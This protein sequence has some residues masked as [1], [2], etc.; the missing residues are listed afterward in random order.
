VDVGLAGTWQ[1]DVTG[2]IESS[3]GNVTLRLPRD[4]GVVVNARTSFGD[5]LTS[6]LSKGSLS[7]TYVNGRYGKA[8]VTLR[9]NVRSSAGNVRLT[10]MP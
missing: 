8:A 7:D 10:V 4:V 1:A 6:G 2:T 3:A 9:L 5:V